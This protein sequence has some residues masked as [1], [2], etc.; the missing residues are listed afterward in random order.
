MISILIAITFSG[1]MGAAHAAPSPVAPTEPTLPRITQEPEGPAPVDLESTAPSNR[2]EITAADILR[3]NPNAKQVRENAVNIA[4][5][6]DVL[7][8]PKRTGQDNTQARTDICDYYNLCFWEH[9]YADLFGAGLGFY[10]CQPANAIMNLGG[11][12][13]PD[14]AWVGTGS[15]APKWNDRI[16]SF[17]NNQTPGTASRFYNYLGSNNWSVVVTSYAFDYESNMHNRNAN[18]IVDGIHVCTE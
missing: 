3:A 13:Y 7:L 6:V 9:S 8:P 18:D 17:E 2:K 10:A 14:G 1:Q 15:S 4:P 5:G 11:M 16:S 12:R